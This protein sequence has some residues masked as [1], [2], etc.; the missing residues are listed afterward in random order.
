VDP[1][2]VEPSLVEPVAPPV[3]VRVLL[4]DE[5]ALFREG[6]GLALAGIDDIE[7]AGEAVDGDDAAVQ[8]ELLRPDVV[9]MDVRMP[10]GSGAGAIAR[11]R[12]AQPEVA[13][14][15]LTGSGDDDDLVDSLR[16]GATGYLLKDASVEEVAEAIR[17]VAR[18]QGALSSLLTAKVLERLGELLRRVPDDDGPRLTGRELD[19]LRLVVKGLTNREIA[20]DL[21]ISQNTVKNHVRNILEKLH[22]RSR[23]EAATLAVRE[24]LLDAQ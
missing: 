7:V 9:V 17:G 24:R 16:A 3:V 20:R 13:V 12:A 23:T 19:V 1:T 21:F 5:H 22:V 4:V 6:L 11:I 10:E 8:S 2:G 18:G 14:L 15:V